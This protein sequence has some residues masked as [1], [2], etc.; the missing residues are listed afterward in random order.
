MEAPSY[1]FIPLNSLND[2][3]TDTD[4]DGELVADV[5][6]DALVPIVR[7]ELKKW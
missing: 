2:I 1:H 3:S 7:S 6:P 4:D 5:D